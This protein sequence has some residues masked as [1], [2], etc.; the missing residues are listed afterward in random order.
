MPAKPFASRA[1]QKFMN[2]QARRGMA[3]Q[4]EVDAQNLATKPL[5]GYKRLADYTNNANAVAMN[6]RRKRK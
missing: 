5:G 2:A 6:V 3:K 4:T 1:Q